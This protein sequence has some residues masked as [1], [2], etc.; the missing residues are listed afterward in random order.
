MVSGCSNT[1]CSASR[2]TRRRF[3]AYF[4]RVIVGNVE[5]MFCSSCGLMLKL[6]DTFSSSCGK[7]EF[8]P[9]YN[10]SSGRSAGKYSSC[11]PPEFQKLLSGLIMTPL[12][13]A[14]CYG[15]GTLRQ[16]GQ[17]CRIAATYVNRIEL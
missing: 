14:E 11:R 12:S 15:N 9:F 13:R 16:R 3:P 2:S 10:H 5:I 4:S 1:W 7:G 6:A 8:S 17:N